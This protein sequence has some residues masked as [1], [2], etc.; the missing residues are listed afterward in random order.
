MKRLLY[1]FVPVFLTMLSSDDLKAQSVTTDVISFKLEDV[2]ELFMPPDL[3]MNIKFSDTNGNDILEAEESGKVLLNII[4][5]GGKADDV[6]VTVTPVSVGS[7]ISMPQNTFITTVPKEGSTLVEIPMTASIDAP[8]GQA[9]FDIKV[10]EPM[11]YDIEAAMELSTF[12]FQK[13]MLTMNGVS[14]VDVGKGLRA[15]KDNPDGKFQKGEVVRA[16][17]M[18]QNI[19]VG[20]ARNIRYKI[21]SED[22][23]VYLLTE[24]DKVSEL[25]GSLGDMLIEQTREIPFRLTTNNNYVNKGEYLPLYLIVSEDK[26][27]GDI[28][29]K[30]IPIPLDATPVKPEVIKVK[31]D[32]DRLMASLG[33]KV[34]SDDSRVTS[35]AQ[36]KDI[37]LA[38]YG[39][40]LYADA[41]AILIGSE[42]YQDTTIP[43]A[44]Y[45]KRDA[46]VMTEYFKTS[47]GIE[48]VRTYTDDGV[49]K[50]TLRKLFDPQKGDLVK[51]IIPG[52]TD[53]FVYYSGHGV[54]EGDDI[55]L[56][57]Y[58]VPKSFI[59]DE[60]FSLNKMYEDL[61]SLN[62]KSVT[63][64]L[65]A[66]F[67]GGSRS[68]KAHKSESIAGQKLVI[69][70]L[71]QMKQPWLDNPEFRLFTS[72]RGDQASQGYDRSLSG[73]FTYYL[74][75]GLQGEADEDENG[76]I[77]MRELVDYVTANVEKT[78]G[79]SQTPQFY[80]NRDFIIEKIR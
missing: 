23:N 47:L 54:P 41:V 78:S 60:G 35:D 14:I 17:V 79:G 37:M 21:I 59:F 57:P 67:S 49:T 38:P 25:S 61:A 53:V 13:A 68:S 43:Q 4:N 44:P 71:R 58:D 48:D 56:I 5:K 33:T 73:L 64:I 10:S 15:L 22:P 40:A 9:R 20:E 76:T 77:S 8:T 26:G 2:S 66:C 52:K 3:Y 75:V 70:D 39:E 18:I 62:A 1:F 72:S 69:T 31:A 34:Y 65:D 19:G 80:G 46:E 24:S 51:N 29:K 27:F 30:Q 63:V 16:S 7:G 74:A 12:A 45:A 28:N 55:F 42:R 50:M 32:T 6:K 11:G 36:I